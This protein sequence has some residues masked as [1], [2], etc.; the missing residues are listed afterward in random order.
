MSNSL[1]AL[2]IV[3]GIALSQFASAT[4]LT[5]AEP[6]P[7]AGGSSLRNL[8]EL[9]HQFGIHL[10]S[11][12][13]AAECTQEGEICTSSEQCCAGLECSGGPPATCTTED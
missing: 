8:A 6:A 10:I 3:V 5:T 2:A 9:P 13:R 4:D 11:K 1:L 12:A 7:N